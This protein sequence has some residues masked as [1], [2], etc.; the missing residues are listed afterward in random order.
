MKRLSLF[1]CI[2]ILLS[3]LVPARSGSA[4]GM[5]YAPTGY[6]AAS[7]YFRRLNALRFTGDQRFDIVNIAASQVG[8][9]E[10]DSFSQLDG[11]NGSGSKNFTEYGYWFGTEVMERDEG[12][13]YAWCA[14]FVSWCARQS[15][16]PT[17]VLSNAAY[18]RPDSAALSGGY[19]YFHLDAINPNGYEPK[20][21]D[22]VFIDWEADGTWDHVGF[23]CYYDGSSIGTIEGNAEDGI[24]HRVYDKN[25]PVIRA[26]GSPAY[27][28]ESSGREG[29]V[30]RARF[31]AEQKVKQAAESAAR[32]MAALTSAPD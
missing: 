2:M 24:L 29:E 26:Y 31:E 25:D 32:L 30:F 18:A 14:M 17:S 19:G 27:A 13:F 12:F 10:G 16:V 15:G 11:D 9:H 6:Y 5:S 4:V 21:G 28:G 22:L 23:V 20:C 1:L 8:Y 7:K 3:A